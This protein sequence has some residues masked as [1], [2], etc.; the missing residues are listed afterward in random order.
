MTA[1][2]PMATGSK[3]IRFQDIDGVNI[4]FD[5][6]TKRVKHEDPVSGK[7]TYEVFY[8][9][10]GSS[11]ECTALIDLNWFHILRRFDRSTPEY[12]LTRRHS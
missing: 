1:N 12:S 2:A 7:T 8:L 4:P 6:I 9:P 5:A 3:A 10:A 11:D